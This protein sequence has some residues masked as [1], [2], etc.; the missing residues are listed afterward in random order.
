[1]RQAT[2][3]DHTLEMRLYT[4]GPWGR[5]EA[6]IYQPACLLAYQGRFVEAI[7]KAE[8]AHIRGCGDMHGVSF[9]VVT[10]TRT[11]TTTGPLE[12]CL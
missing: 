7:H 2:E 1:M 11:V 8:D 12:N 6:G 4:D 3:T 10:T 9:R 5:C